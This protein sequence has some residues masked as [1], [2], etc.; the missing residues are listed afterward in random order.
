MIGANLKTDNVIEKLEVNYKTYCSLKNVVPEMLISKSMKD[1][2]NEIL[3]KTGYKE[4][5]AS[6]MCLDDFLK[7]LDAFHQYNLHFQ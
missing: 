7:L 1:I 2:I 3:E 5:R 4:H 6:K